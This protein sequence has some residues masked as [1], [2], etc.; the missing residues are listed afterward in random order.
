MYFRSRYEF[1]KFYIKIEAAVIPCLRLGEFW[2]A[3]VPVTQSV[4]S[5]LATGRP[6]AS[7]RPSMRSAAKDETDM[8]AIERD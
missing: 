8:S 1:Y 2:G 4:T 7:T 6:P 3:P 5:A